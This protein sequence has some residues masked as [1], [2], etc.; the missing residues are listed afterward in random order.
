MI[1]TTADDVAGHLVCA[2][3]AR[4]VASSETVDPQRIPNLSG[5]AATHEDQA[6]KAVGA[7]T[8]HTILEYFSGMDPT[9]TSVDRLLVIAA[10]MVRKAANG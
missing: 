3:Y 1:Q 8:V 9:R 6:A 10:E 4:R 2:F 5:I 7:E